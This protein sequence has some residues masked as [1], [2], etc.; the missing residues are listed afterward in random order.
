MD[1]N[2]LH[3]TG[4]SSIKLQQSSII[5]PFIFIFDFIKKLQSEI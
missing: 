3:G 2:K 4:I 5:C 1:E